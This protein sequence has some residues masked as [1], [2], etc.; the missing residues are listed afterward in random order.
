MTRPICRLRQRK[1]P[2]HCSVRLQRSVSHSCHGRAF[3]LPEIEGRIVYRSSG[4]DPIR[5]E[6]LGYRVR[7]IRAYGFAASTALAGL[8][9]ALYVSASHYIGPQTAGV[10]FSAQALIWVAVGGVG[11]L[12]G[13]LIG[14]LAVKWGEYYLSSRLGLQ[15]S[16]PLFLGIILI[17]VVVVA[18]QGLAGLP[19]Q[20]HA[21]RQRIGS[22]QTSGAQPPTHADIAGQPDRGPCNRAH[23]TVRC[24]SSNDVSREAK[25]VGMTDVNGGRRLRVACDVGGTF[26]DICVLNEATGRTARREGT[27][28]AR[29]HR[30]CPCRASRAPGSICKTSRSSRMARRWPPTH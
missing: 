30:R 12:F 20:I 22:R 10:I 14:T 21:L 11:F 28:H 15:D 2:D 4:D 6:A 13:P 26:T 17:L 29:S 27:L 3:L 7:L 18:P 1:Q 23:E 9:G 24:Q 25:G 8:A 5:L 16:W 19:Q